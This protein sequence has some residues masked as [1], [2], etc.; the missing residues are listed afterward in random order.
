MNKL[1]K[2]EFKKIFTKKTVYILFIIII[3]IVVLNNVLNNLKPNANNNYLEQELSFYEERMKELDYTNEQDN[4]YYIELKTSYDQCKLLINYERNS[5]QY[6]I[7]NN[8]ST[9]NEL[10]LRINQNTYGMNREQKELEDANQK[11]KEIIQKFDSDNWKDFVQSEIRDVK[12]EINFYEE[13]IENIKD[14]KTIEDINSSLELAKINKQA[15]EWRIEK[16]IPYG[17]NFKSS[18]IEEYVR[19]F[20]T[21]NELKNKENKD[22]YEIQEYNMSLKQMNISKYYIEN[23]IDIQNEYDGRYLLINLMDEYGIIIMVFGIIIAGTIVSN[24]YQRGTIKLLLTRPYSRNKILFSKYIVSILMLLI[25]IIVALIAQYI[26]GGIVSGFNVYNVP[27]VEF[28]LNTN[29]VI[30]M[31]I[32]KY[33]LLIIIFKLPIYILLS[34]LGFALSTL[35]MNSAI[36]IAIPV[37]GGTIAAEMLN[38]FIERFKLL[39]YFVCANWDLSIYLFG[40]VGI[41]EGLNLYISLLICMIYLLIMLVTTFIVFKK[42]D[43]KNI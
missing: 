35:T 31:S 10:L 30:V 43:I 24:E 5:W 37:L 6:Y 18:K 42:R 33:A 13:Q 25:F 3:G 16:N 41:A 22:N 23:D 32:L 12:N 17:N 26:I 1:I 29:S 8:T 21:V 9:I 28:D 27:V 4:S 19:N 7:I 40:G 39:K 20:Q 38:V 15:L 14:K 34:T 36:S 2:N 11:L